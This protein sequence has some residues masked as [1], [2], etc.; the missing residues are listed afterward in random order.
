[1]ILLP[2]IYALGQTQG[3]TSMKDVELNRHRLSKKEEKQ[4]FSQLM[5]N[6]TRIILRRTKDKESELQCPHRTE[7]IQWDIKHL[8]DHSAHFSYTQSF[9]FVGYSLIRNGWCRGLL[10]LYTVSSPHERDILLLPLLCFNGID[11][12]V[13]KSYAFLL[14]L[15]VLLKQI[16]YVNVLQGS[17]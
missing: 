15:T 7:R 12:R 5:H 11:Y 16:K 14:H 4:Y 2:I 3:I 13:N 8:K 10:Q 9:V 1:M 6:T 17:T